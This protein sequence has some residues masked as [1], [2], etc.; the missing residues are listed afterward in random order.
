MEKLWLGFQS[1]MVL[2]I[3]K[4]SLGQMNVGGQTSF[5][6]MFYVQMSFGQMPFS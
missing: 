3:N 2:K 1:I 5:G 6:Q 4:K